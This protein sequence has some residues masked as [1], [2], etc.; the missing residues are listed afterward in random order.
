MGSQDAEGPWSGHGPAA[1]AKFQ[2][3]NNLYGQ[4]GAP[5]LR[6]SSRSR[7][8]GQSLAHLSIPLSKG[9]SGQLVFIH[10]FF[11]K[12]DGWKMCELTEEESLRSSGGTAQ[13]NTRTARSCASVAGGGEGSWS[14][15]RQ[16]LRVQVGAHSR[17]G[18]RRAH[19][20]TGSF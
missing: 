5:C 6:I 1:T 20:C 7:Y 9:H 19:K 8:R 12:R 10:V 4:A 3:F 18:G 17:E 14:P 16:L 11:D 2:D 13:H 15:T